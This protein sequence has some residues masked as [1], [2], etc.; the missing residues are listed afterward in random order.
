MSSADV[1]V[2][3][4]GRSLWRSENARSIR[5]CDTIQKIQWI[6][7]TDRALTN[8]VRRSLLNTLRPQT[9]GSGFA[10]VAGEVRS[11][12]QRSAGAAREIKLLSED[13]VRQV[14][15][16]DALV[17]EA[18]H[19]MQQV[20]GSVR[21]AAATMHEITL[22]SREQG[23]GIAQFN[24]AMAGLDVKTRQDAALVE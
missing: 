6:R 23:S 2:V 5:R 8:R 21:G 12:A 13:S 10:V 4:R 18:G 9:K 16:G 7:F 20:V 1:F 17:G 15:A 3:A 11:L 22:A 24:E 19:T 14:G